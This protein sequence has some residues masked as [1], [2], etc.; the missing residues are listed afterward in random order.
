MGNNMGFHV[1]C[2]L[3][4]LV[5]NAL[6]NPVAKTAFDKVCVGGLAAGAYLIVIA[7]CYLFG[8]LK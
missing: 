7:G 4:L 5:G 2:A 6:F 3:G 1:F 8:V